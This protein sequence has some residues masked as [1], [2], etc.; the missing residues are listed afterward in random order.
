M[1][2][3]SFSILKKTESSSARRGTIS[4]PHGEIQTPAFAV[5][6]T[7][8]TVRA[9]DSAHLLHTN[10]QLVLANTYH[11]YLE[12]GEDIVAAAG[13]FG[14]FMGW[15]GPTMT[16][17]G[18][19]QV[20]SLGAAY[21][22]GVSKVAKG[23]AASHPEHQDIKDGRIVEGEVEG[24]K[25]LVTIDD[26]GVTFKS[27][28]DGSMHR[29]TPESSMEIQWKLGADMIFAFD[30][31]TSPTVKKEYQIEA[32]ERTHAWA[33]RSLERHNQ[34]DPENKQALFAVVQGGQYEDLRKLSATTLADMK[35]ESG[36]LFDGFGIGGSFT[37][38]DL[39]IAVRAVTE[40]LPENK[41][42]HLL[43]IGEPLDI[44]D[45]V[46]VGC[47]TFDCIIPTRHGRHGNVFTK[48][49][50]FNFLNAECRNDF[51]PIEKD[52]ECT[53]CKRFTKAYLSHLGRSKEMLAATLASVHN[54]YFLE[55]LM[56]DIRKAIEENNFEEFAKEFKKNYIN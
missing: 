30:E 10:T 6:A 42:R 55:K 14:P 22:K 36:A 43:G 19:F 15:S 40:N 35:T 44:L 18:G 50:R 23:E 12:P 33:L 7:K 53:T 51:T 48:N 38:D 54:I 5:V 13:G 46:A 20:F 32:L 39:P 26:D 11:L 21:G 28:R 24:E 49:G 16:D 27:H 1:S 37:K 17:S 34:L 25:S 41:P 56:G 52:C 9:V 8:A 2:A 45:A 3:F 47:D 31:C 4:T 29:F